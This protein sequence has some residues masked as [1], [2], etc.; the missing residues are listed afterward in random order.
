M[1]PTFIQPI[2]DSS[3]RFDSLLRLSYRRHMLEAL[4][5]SLPMGLA[6]STV[7]LGYALFM[8]YNLDKSPISASI[9]SVLGTTVLGSWLWHWRVS[10]PECYSWVRGGM[11]G[12]TSGWFS[13]YFGLVGGFAYQAILEPGPLL[14]RMAVAL[15]IIVYS[16]VL[17]VPLIFLFG[18]VNIVLCGLAGILLTTWNNSQ[19]SR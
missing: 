14:D 13:L 8:H 2:S 6:C 12:L 4:K 11:V 10:K 1:L 18:W 17:T 7:A 19:A 9:S 15:K 5:K 3:V 16:P